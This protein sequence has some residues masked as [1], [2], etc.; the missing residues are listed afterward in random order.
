ML[1][2]GFPVDDLYQVEELTFCYHIVGCWS[3]SDAFSAPVE[4]II[5]DFFPYAVNTV[6]YIIDLIFVCW[7]HLVFL[8]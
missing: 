6:Y 7:T 8:G 4:V 5:S 2:V 3:L 1:A